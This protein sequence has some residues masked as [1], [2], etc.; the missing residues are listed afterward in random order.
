M[1]SYSN[2]GGNS[3]VL[4]YE[5]GRDYIKVKFM[6]NSIYT[7]T[8]GSTG[9]QNILIMKKLASQGQGLNS[10]INTEVRQDYASKE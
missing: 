1:K 8:Y 6:D 10:F 3:N 2:L 5:S 4:A 7:Y 9:A